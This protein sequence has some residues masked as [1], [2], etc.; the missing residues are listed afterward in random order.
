MNTFLRGHPVLAVKKE[1]VPDG[2]NSFWTFCVEYLDGGGAVAL[3]AGGRA[4]KVDYK[5]VLKPEEFGCSA[6][7]AAGARPWGGEGGCSCLCGAQ[8]RATGADGPEE[9]E[10]HGG[11][12]NSSLFYRKERKDRTDKGPGDSTGSAFCRLTPNRLTHFELVGARS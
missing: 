2:E 3:S 10:Q 6:V 1:F 9:G 8:Q 12:E 4:P 7:C 11:V 5:E